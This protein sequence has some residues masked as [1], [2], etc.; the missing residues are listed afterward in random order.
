[1]PE[2]TKPAQTTQGDDA[3]PAPTDSK[4][5]K[6]SQSAQHTRPREI[7]GPEGLEPTRYGDWERNGRCSDF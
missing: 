7:G 4:T 6:R 2:P 3:G 1:M 5:G